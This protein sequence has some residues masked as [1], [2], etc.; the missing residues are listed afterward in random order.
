MSVL[1][2]KKYEGFFALLL[3]MCTALSLFMSIACPA[4][5][6]AYSGTGAIVNILDNLALSI[7]ADAFAVFICFGAF[8]WLRS[9]FPVE[10][11]NMLLRIVCFV[12]AVVWLLGRCFE[13]D[14]SVD[15]LSKGPGQIVKAL[16]YILGSYNLLMQLWACV[17][18]FFAS[19]R[20]LR[21]SRFAAFVTRHSFL[22][23]FVA[24]IV[25]ILPVWIVC[26]PGYMCSDAYCQLA[27]YF[28]IYEFVSH[29][30]PVHTLLISWP[31]KLGM[32]LGSSNMGLY[33]VICAQMLCFAAVFAYM[34]HTMMVLSAPKWLVLI[35]F[36]TVA[37]SPS[38]V[39]VA[40]MVLKDNV[41]SYGV[42][43][44]TIEI[45]Y[46]LRLKEAYWKTWWHVALLA[47]SIMMVMLLRN[48]G[49]YLLY[50][51]V[52]LML[53]WFI[54]QGLKKRQLKLTVFS[55]LSFVL[56]ILVSVLIQNAVIAHYDVAPG[57]RREALSLPFQ[58]TARYIYERGDTV[59]A[60]DRAI[61]DKVI[62]YEDISTEYDPMISDPVKQYFRDECSMGD[63]IAYAKVWLKQGI[64][65]PHVYAKATL[66]QN[67]PLLC[68][69]KTT[70]Y[71]KLF[72]E[73]P[74]HYHISEPLGIHEV[75]VADGV[76][77]IIIALSG[78]MALLPVP[79]F[80]SN[81]PV[82]SIF[83]LLLCQDALR[84]RKYMFLTC[85]LPALITMGTVVL[86][87][88]VDPRYA[89]ALIYSMPLLTA[90][91]LNL[92]TKK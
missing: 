12:V 82:C 6:E 58:Q 91:Y 3:S 42:L 29:H 62:S 80:S 61:I 27:Y 9:S 45:V 53:V 13:I 2:N 44:F 31:V 75:N 56:P 24:I 43:L 49:K 8:Y 36:L 17:Q 35:S 48:N 89:F 33:L 34:L 28:D 68:P 86:A 15:H 41:Y 59:T 85:A 26:Y 81:L 83:L 11:D 78:I 79:G 7:G 46:L 60:E 32:I 64:S 84:K 5:L 70:S 23:F 39:N 19:G 52:P 88:L 47:L 25:F 67:Y 76:E 77:R 71:Q 90:V 16:V 30:P 57:S 18:R 51:F 10:R 63:I 54:W 65:A 1:K 37:L 92:D 87:P 14:N 72:T 55:C 22:T 38:Y 69:W 21:E 4:E 20:N 66:N 50:V 73:S 40:A 74:I